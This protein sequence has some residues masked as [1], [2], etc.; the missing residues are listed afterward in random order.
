M[1]AIN[2]TTIVLWPSEP[3][4]H[5]IR[6]RDLTYISD[7]AADCRI[8][9]K[10]Y[11]SLLAGARFAAA[12]TVSVSATGTRL[13]VV[14]RLVAT[15]TVS[16]NSQVFLPLQNPLA[17]R[18]TVQVQTH[19][20]LLTTPT[21]SSASTI[22]VLVTPPTLR[23]PVRFR[24][25]STIRVSSSTPFLSRLP[26]FFQAAATIRVGSNANL[27]LVG[28][29]ATNV[30]ITFNG[31]EV[32]NVR[33]NTIQ[34]TDVLNEQPN[35]ATFLL[36]DRPGIGPPSIGTVVRIGLRD[37]LT[38][39]MLFAG[40]VKQVQQYY[41]PAPSHPV[42]QITCEDFTFLFNRRRVIGTWR[43]TSVS[44][45]ATDIVTR[46][47]AGFATAGI[48]AGLP[49]VTVTFNGETP[50]D[51]LTKLANLI[52]GYAGGPD[53]QRVVW[54]FVTD[55][56]AN[57][58]AIVN[59]SPLLM[60]EPPIRQTLDVTQTRTRVDVQGA[61]TSVGGPDDC[62][63]GSEFGQLPL[64]ETKIFTP[65]T[66]GQVITDDAQILNYTDVL[67][68]Q[69]ATVVRGNVAAPIGAPV[70]Q[71]ASGKSGG[72]QGAGYQWKVAFANALG[73]TEVG[74]ASWPPL[75]ADPFPAPGGY[76]G[77]PG[78]G[79]AV[80]NAQVGPL[81]GTYQYAVS[82]V[83]SLGETL[84]GP[85]ATIQATPI[86]QPYAISL[87]EAPYDPGPL[88]VGARYRYVCSFLTT[89][90]ETTVGAENSIVPSYP[91]VPQLYNFQQLNFGGLTSGATYRYGVSIV[92]KSGESW[93]NWW[94]LNAAYTGS[95]G[96]PS[97]TGQFDFNGR[98]TPGT[99]YYGCTWYNDLFGETYIVNQLQMPVSGPLP[100]GQVG[101]RLQ[102]ALPPM[103]YRADGIRVYRAYQDGAMQL[104]F[105]RRA[106][107]YTY[108]FN[109]WD[110][111]P[112][113][114][115]GSMWP[116]APLR[117][118]GIATYFSVSASSA[119]GVVARRLYRSKA[120]GSELFLLGEIQN[121]SD[122]TYLDTAADDVLTVR[123]PAVPT[124]G[125][126]VV[127]Y[128]PGNPGVP[129]Y[130]GYTGRRVYR[131]KA[132]GFAYYRIADFKEM[133]TSSFVDN[134][135]D[136]SLTG[137]GPTNPSTAGGCAFQLT[138]L[139]IG[140][141]GTLARRIYRTT[142]NGQEL[143]LL[144]ELGDNT[145]RSYL[146]TTADTNLGA[147]L[148][149]LVNTAGAAA[150]KLTQVPRGG[151]SVTQRLIYRTKAGGGDFLYAGAITN[152]VDTEYIDDKEDSALG[153]PPVAVSTIGAL[154]GDTTI[155]VQSA[156]G[157]PS[158][159]WL[160]ADSQTIR[161]NGIQFGIPGTS[162][163]LIG[164]PPLLA[165]TSLSRS[166]QTAVA[167]T[168]AGHGFRVG[169]RIVVLGADQQEYNGTRTITAIPTSVQFQYV[170]NGAPQSP[171]TGVKI[172]TSA[173]GAI[174]GAIGGGTTVMSVPMLVGVSGIGTPV[175]VGSN[176]ALWVVSDS[177]AGQAALAALEGGDGIHEYLV[178]DSTLDSIAACAARGQAELLQFQ[179]VGVQIDYVTRDRLTRSGALV[180]INLPPPQSISGSFRIQQVR[181][182]QID[183]AKRLY[184]RYAVRCSNTKY[185]LIDLL[186]HVVLNHDHAA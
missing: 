178:T 171:A 20:H 51:A 182:D 133:T 54:L 53:Y 14:S 105:E 83:T 172:V 170:V 67:P 115:A 6:L 21:L 64:R 149:P 110:G 77:S 38:Q 26:Q 125:R 3:D 33:I 140:P 165:V 73:E 24:A 18:S 81:V 128:L 17:A 147:K 59:T 27:V 35:T 23:A 148:A 112:Q 135:P 142:G 13:N 155:A 163:L 184:P 4:A 1:A 36:D 145:T 174:T 153:R 88:E 111:V 146:D 118:G 55:P 41:E 150:V 119:P 63:I 57:P 89:Y 65:G 129:S 52:G 76:F 144:A 151:P 109:L 31:V 99:Y 152:N 97:Y 49:A 136:T 70:A 160:D 161:Y 96:M 22:Q 159:G 42:W 179:Y 50:M 124:S 56:R 162:D 131:T 12:A 173:P 139:P 69:L 181:I 130:T 121:N 10:G 34:I 132:N 104:I 79:V 114:E 44:Q 85:R 11:G 103:G 107:N 7:F 87:A 78:F 157:W 82:Y 169:Q 74:P 92:T 113:S 141:T 30:L 86:T 5:V 62:N 95:P 137:D 175:P 46:F 93:M 8:S 122:T 16:I 143:R 156:A 19:A 158:T 90:G 102:I 80:S 126:A 98:I 47:T 138:E 60:M 37:M 68:G 25:T 166:G 28:R 75:Q 180:S 123:N 94:S 134:T 168:A 2:K 61:Q 167:Q 9:L 186:R 101:V 100:P 45:I 106:T 108:P 71:I 58:S 72:L 116:V 185:S 117:G 84:V 48:A 127:V 39:N 164:V 32:P 177:A 15:S 29:G 120:N 176:V 40:T 43:N 183:I 66:G 91:P 154:A